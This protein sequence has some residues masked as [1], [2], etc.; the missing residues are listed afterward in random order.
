MDT[1]RESEDADLSLSPD[2]R[3]ISHRKGGKMRTNLDSKSPKRGSKVGRGRGK[4]S[5]EEMIQKQE[6]ASQIH[7]ENER[8]RWVVETDFC[9]NINIELSILS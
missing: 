2:S 5:I 3:L 7:N 9:T 6:T 8:Y 1:D 4:V